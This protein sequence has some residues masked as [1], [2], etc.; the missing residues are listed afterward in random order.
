[1]AGTV[2]DGDATVGDAATGATVV[3]GAVGTAVGVAPGAATVV[4]GADVAVGTG[5]G[6]VGGAPLPGGVALAV[7]PP[8]VGRV[9]QA[10][11]KNAAAPSEVPSRRRRDT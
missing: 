1:V 11:T 9:P 2:G 8:F 7:I 10:A 3:G 5:V 6:A 4:V